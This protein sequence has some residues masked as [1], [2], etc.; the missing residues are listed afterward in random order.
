MK[1]K[2]PIYWFIA[3]LSVVDAW[4][5][6]HPNTLGRLGVWFYKYQYIS[7]FPKAL[8]TVGLSV[9]VA[10]GIA[11][12]A[13]RQLRPTTAQKVLGA[14]LGVSLVLLGGIILKFS[15]G[16]YAHTGKAFIWGFY[17]LPVLLLVVFGNGLLELRRS[18]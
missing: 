3:I 17:L 13:K 2:A 16:T 11:E 8:L 14:G 9:G 18:R 6:S 5:I 4:L 10:L 15:G 1:N 7:T 12:W